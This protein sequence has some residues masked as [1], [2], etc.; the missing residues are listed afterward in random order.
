MP[1]TNVETAVDARTGVDKLWARLRVEAASA[2]AEEP[3]L[4]SFLNAAILRHDKFAHA[5]AYRIA[6]KMADAQLDSMLARDVAEEAIEGD[7]QIVAQAAADMIAV[8]ERDPAC[9]S[10]LQPFLYFKGYHA[11][12]AHRIAHWLWKQGRQTPGRRALR[13][14]YPPRSPDR[15]RR[16]VRPCHLRGDRRDRR[17]G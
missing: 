12:Q 11:L 13:S 1:L 7:P 6:S 5:L 4:A 10:L 15:Q 17:G 8:D 3:I 16:D 2:A 9:L 14:R